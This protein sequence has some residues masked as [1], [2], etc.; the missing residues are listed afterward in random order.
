MLLRLGVRRGCVR[1]GGPLARCGWRAAAAAVA[2]GH[3]GLDSLDHGAAEG[4][5]SGQV[6]AVLRQPYRCT[7][8]QRAALGG[9]AQGVQEEVA[10]GLLQTGPRL[11]LNP[12][13]APTSPSRP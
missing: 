2:A 3:C 4:E 12:G 13:T 5:R 9:G 7:A 8:Y 11:R 1:D 10:V 6:L